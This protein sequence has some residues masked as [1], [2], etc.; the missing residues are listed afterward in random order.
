MPLVCAPQTGK[1]PD[2]GKSE[3]LPG[4]PYKPGFGKKTAGDSSLALSIPPVSLF[5]FPYVGLPN[6][7]RVSK[8]R[9]Y[10][11][12]FGA[13]CTALFLLGSAARA[14]TD[15]TTERPLNAVTITGSKKILFDPALRP[16]L[17]VAGNG[18]LAQTLG[19]QNLV[20]VKTYG[21]GLLSTLSA[22]GT[23]AVHTPVIWHGFSM[24]N[25]VNATPDP[26]IE[27]VP[28]N[29]KVA[30]YPGGQ[31]GLYGSGAMGGTLQLNPMFDRPAGISAGASAE[32]GSFGRHTESFNLGY[33]GQRTS[34]YAS[35]RLSQARNNF[36][37][38]NRTIVSK[39]VQRL[40]HAEAA[41]MSF[42]TDFRHT[43]KKGGEITAS[44]WYQFNR[45]QIPPTMFG[46]LTHALQIDESVRSYVGWSNSFKGHNVSAKTAFVYD[47]LF[48]NDDV[49]LKPSLM[50]QYASLSRVEYDYTFSKNH[51]LF[52]GLN[53]S[54][55]Q[56]YMQEYQ[57]LAP[58][59]NQSALFL[60]Y[61]YTLPKNLGE[62]AVQAVEELTDG[63]FTP[64]CPA[65]S[66]LL[67][68][69]PYLP[70]RVRV[71][72]NYRQPTFNDLYWTPGGD[73]NLKPELGFAQEAGIGFEKKFTPKSGTW[74]LAVF[75]TGFH[76]T[77]TNRIAW[78]PGP[79]YWSPVNIDRTRAY[80]AETDFSLKWEKK[81]WSVTATGNYSHTRSIRAKPRFDG[82]PA[83]G[84]QLIYIPLDL[85]SAGIELCYKHTK[86]FY[87][88]RFTGKRYTLTDNSKALDGFQTGS[89]GI[90]QSVTFWGVTAS[91]WFA[92]EN[93]GNVAYEVLEYRPMPGRN[94]RGGISLSFNKKI[95]N[96]D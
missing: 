81:H 10:G 56:V 65:F 36:P 25:T 84:K 19:D 44:L 47:Y 93:I 71:N 6:K 49:I 52:A 92:C 58:H 86:L 23:D 33:R 62:A 9:T 24:Q 40:N 13:I 75:A 74:N 80:G 31:S 21:P 73:P 51:H 38:V 18:S 27:S 2:R 30:Y 43:L 53:H 68:P 76:N 50:V 39:P 22:R 82:D 7:K 29:Y 72:R 78:V 14:Q 67:R 5:L 96:Y 41:G 45:R 87:R 17:E 61:R 70:I 83:F 69:K 55:Y 88:Y 95:P 66:L 48:Y 63:R 8:K 77:M 4:N 34:V 35:A 85:G 20:F 94:Y 59:R 42:N 15:S 11:R 57:G 60:G 12:R 46:T 79:V 1:A 54:Y 26:A 37:F 89:L 91:F 64:F 32:V 3:D 16:R 90:S 28:G